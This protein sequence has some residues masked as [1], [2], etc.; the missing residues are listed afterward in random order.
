MGIIKKVWVCKMPA[1]VQSLII[2]FAR[3]IHS[4]PTEIIGFL[5]DTSH[6]D[7]ISLKILLNRWLLH[8][9]LFTGN[10]TKNTTFSALV[11]MLELRDENIENLMVVG[12]DPSHK[13]VNSEVNAPFKIMSTLLRYLYNDNKIKKM[14]GHKDAKGEGQISSSYKFGA[15]PNYEDERLDTIGGDD[16]DYGMEMEDE[17]GAIPVS[18]EDF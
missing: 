1:I 7:R 15:E 13:N 14:K 9:P 16:E 2:V 3:L 5:Q 6:M 4:N 17:D 11:R 12:Y 18:M 8:Q 10:Y